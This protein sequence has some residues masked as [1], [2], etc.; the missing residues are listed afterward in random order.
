MLNQFSRTELL[1]GKEAMD[2]LNSAHVAVFGVGGVGGFAVEALVRSGI[3]HIDIIDDDKVCLTNL[4]RQ[5]IATRSSVGKYKVDVMKERILDINPDA[6]VNTFKCFYLPDTRDQ[7][8]F[9]K[10]D[11]VV[12][13]VDTVTAKIQLILQAKEAGIPIISSMGAGNKLD[14]TQFEVADISQTS[15]CPLARVM[16]QA[17]KKR[18]IKNVKVVYSKE[19]PMRPI[20]DMSISCRAHCICPPGSQHKCTDRRDIPGSTAFVPSVAG[21]IIAGEIIKDLTKEATARARAKA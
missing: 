18:G 13:A 3:Q 21:L 6:K 12:D 16:R 20:E 8:D 9:S 10:Y 14:P 11:Y 15:V 1:L 17:C 2:I 4:N 5:I 7:F 19:K